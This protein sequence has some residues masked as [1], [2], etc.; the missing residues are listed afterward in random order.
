[1]FTCHNLT[2]RGVMS[3]PTHVSQIL[4]SS[5]INGTVFINP[6][7]QT[8]KATLS[9]S[10]IVLSGLEVYERLHT[11]TVQSVLFRPALGPSV[12]PRQSRRALDV[13]L[14]SANSQAFLSS[15]VFDLPSSGDW[16]GRCRAIDLTGPGE[17]ILSSVYTLSSTPAADDSAMICIEAVKSVVIQNSNISAAGLSLLAFGQADIHDSALGVRPPPLSL[18]CLH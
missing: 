5:V 12:T 14:V 9:I 11:L 7:T 4:P 17:V 10:R 8:P 2:L 13:D 16:K 18:S 15:I 1:V 3:D 6:P